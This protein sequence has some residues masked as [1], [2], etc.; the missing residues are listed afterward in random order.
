VSSPP[1]RSISVVIPALNERESLPRVLGDLPWDAL[2][3]VVV[4]DN[5]STDGTPEVARQGGARVVPEPRR[6]YGRACLTGIAALEAT[7]VVVFLDADY[8]D[9]P[10]E[11]PALAGPIL[12]GRADLV[13][14]SRVLGEREP[15]A[16]L[17]QARFGNLLSVMLIR[18]LC[19]QTYTDLGPFRAISRRALD[20]LE[21]RDEDFGWTVEMQVKAARAGLRVVEVPVRYRRRIGRSKI[22]GTL[23][24]TVL[25]GWK[26]LATIAKHHRWR[27]SLVPSRPTDT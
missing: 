4:V 2:H 7:D 24:G 12:E 3:E 6:G 19:G 9:H 25:A 21:M 27:P 13:I 20:L 17:P 1:P 16:L 14:G 23:R 26:I 10:E 15:G 18:S 22:T 8:S 5:G 11:L